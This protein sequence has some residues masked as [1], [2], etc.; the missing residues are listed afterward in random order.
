MTRRAL[1]L[2]CCLITM[3]G[4]ASAQ[5][6]AWTEIGPASIGGRVTAVAADPSNDG[7]L[8]VGTPAGGVWRTTTGGTAWEP[9]NLGLSGIP[10]SALAIDPLDPQ[11]LV[12]G[13]G[14]LADG[15]AVAR[16]AGVLRSTDGGANWALEPVPSAASYIS[17]VLIWP[18]DS[19][20]VLA[21]SDLGVRLSLDGGVTFAETL[22]GE[23]VSMLARDPFS[24]RV[25]AASRS[26]L[27]GS[28]DAG[29]TWDRVSSW[30]LLDIDKFGAGTTHIAFSSRTPGLLYATVQVLGTLNQTARGLV[31]RSVDG[32]LSFD[33]L[34]VPDQFCPGPETC[35]FAQAI[36]IHPD[37]DTCLMLA[38]EAVY[39]SSSA[40]AAWH[41]VSG[42]RGVHRIVRS[43]TDTYAVGRQGVWR[44]GS[45][46]ATASPRNAGLAVTQVTALDA[47]T[48]GV[49]RVLIA[50]VD[51]GTVLGS[52]TSPVVWRTLFADGGRAGTPRFDPFE[53]ETFFTMT[54]EQRVFRT[55]DGGQT[56]VERSTGID[57]L[58]SASPVPPL[59]PAPLAAGTWYTGRLQM[60]ATDDAGV[61]W[62]P[63][64]PAGFP[65][66]GV[67]APSPLIP[68]RIYFAPRAGGAIYKA[69]GDTTDRLD[70]APETTLRVTAILPDPVEQNRLYVGATDTTT[71]RGKLYK[72]ADFGVT[73]TDISPL[74]F[75]PV[76]SLVKDRFGA[77]YAGTTN[78]VYR[79]AND[80]FTW[81]PM[82]RGMQAGGITALRLTGGLLFA[83]TSGRGVFVIAEQ[84]LFSLEA[85]PG[86]GRFLVDGQPVTGPYLAQFDSG[87]THVVEPLL[88]SGSDVREEFLGWSD[89]LTTLTR[90]VTGTG[91]ADWLAATIRRAFR[92]Q[93]AASDGGT[94]AFVPSSPD[95]F[96]VERSFVSMVPVPAPDHQFAGF[97]GDLTGSDGTLGFALMDR[98]RSVGALFVPLRTTMRSEPTGLDLL[99]DGV[100]V[101][102]PRT[103]QWASGSSHTV[104]APALV[105]R[106][107]LDEALLAFDGWSD[108]RPRTHTFVTTRDTF[109]TDLTARYIT[110]LASVD[111]GAAESVRRTTSGAGD[112]PRFTS[113]VVDGGTAAFDTVQF[114]RSVLGD[115][116]LTE[117]A[118][119]PGTPSTLASAHVRQ[120]RWGPAGRVRLAFHN[121]STFE[122][123]VGI[124]LR[125]AAGAPLAARPDAVTIPP[126]AHAT[127][128]LDDH[129]QVPDSFECLLTL[130]ADRPLVMAIHTLRGILRPSTMLDPV[131]LA[132]FL[133][134]DAGVPADPRV[135]VLLATPSTVHQ[136][137]LLNDGFSPLTGTVALRQGDGTPLVATVGSTSTSTWTYS[138]APGAFEVFSVELPTLDVGSGPFATAHVHIEPTPG[139]PAPG[140]Q[141]TEDGTLGVIAGHQAV[142][143]R[144][145]PPS[146]VSLTFGVPID[147]TRRAA[148]L[149]FT[150][151]SAA[152][153]TLTI[154]AVGSAGQLVQSA[155]Q[156]IA[157]GTQALVEDGQVFPALT[158]TFTGRLVVTSSIPI[159][160]VAY[161]RSESARDEEVVVGFP[162]WTT[163]AAQQTYAFATD[164]DGFR[165]DI[166]LS[167]RN[168]SSGTVQLRFVDRKGLRTYLPIP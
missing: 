20:R 98:P 125:D 77:L 141:L 73:W 146:Q 106:D 143:P 84:P 104:S 121:P 145:V 65:E 133:R 67:I 32:G 90:V 37:D 123:R 40:G 22:R 26:G 30:P 39:T 71:Q 5:E 127:V 116:E 56:F 69:D 12:A 105:D 18:G 113:L 130:I 51:A 21:A 8:V 36:A 110:T 119:V 92:L 25:L 57:L 58:Q 139:L 147:R 122:A 137:V 111:V 80:G 103:Y 86:G 148:G 61:S 164:G 59:E 117:V 151:T 42:L 108:L 53:P 138:L 52:G 96:Y 144:S 156:V 88:Q 168:G 150:N 49:P 60:F 160:G 41:V 128:L 63:F 100:P 118:L 126:G 4:T 99:I 38:G 2:C 165:T 76:S 11:R 167:R 6:P 112:A 83:G 23:S 107:P 74:E 97:T 10:L 115:A 66:I 79:S 124:L 3:A 149:V 50:T 31:L 129:M 48:T 55:T 166:W 114:V 131:L 1:N 29:L 75:A 44:F 47:S 135:Q 159:H 17:D 102:A 134:G 82:R 28:D 16:A 13:S 87:S 33:E 35:G 120:D 24:S 89:G 93:A 94:V 45:D 152:P 161:G 7:H 157:A 132:P 43:G 81:A 95:G 155:Q 78:G 34:A 153:A 54:R 136:L 62:A 162:A 15:G 27:F 109:V 72:S 101:V 142:I 9:V 14:T 91:G 163:S 64:R 140:V 154:Q 68:G 19:V 158:D 85:L 70:V 46:W